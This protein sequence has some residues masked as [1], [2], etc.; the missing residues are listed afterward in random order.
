MKVE[1]G[2]P[3]PLKKR[4]V[5]WFDPKICYR[6]M[7]EFSSRLSRDVHFMVYHNIPSNFFEG[8]ESGK[9]YKGW[10]RVVEVY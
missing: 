3:Q 4:S 7:Q 5:Y 2:L 9:L 1:R 6:C 8:K 10:T